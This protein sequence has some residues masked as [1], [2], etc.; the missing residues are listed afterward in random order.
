MELHPE[1]EW[2]L[3]HGQTG[4]HSRLH[5]IDIISDQTISLNQKKVVFQKIKVIEI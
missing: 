2:H 3:P 5:K 1:G 4:T